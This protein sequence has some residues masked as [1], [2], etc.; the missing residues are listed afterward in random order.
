M[1]LDRITQFERWFRDAKAG[2]TFMYHEGFLLQD[3]A[4]DFFLSGKVFRT[5]RGE[6]D[7]VATHAW[8][9]YLNG[10]LELVQR[11]CADGHYQYFAVRR[12]QQRPIKWIGG[13]HE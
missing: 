9:G 2:S 1:A 13:R 11:K 8:L 7:V 12:A 5:P 10:L 4:H 3:K 6:T